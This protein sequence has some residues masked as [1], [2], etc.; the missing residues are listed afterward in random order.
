MRRY[1][2]AFAVTLCLLF[3]VFAPY[4]MGGRNSEF[5]I[6]SAA[7]FAASRDSYSLSSPVRL[8]EAPMIALESGTLSMPHGKSSRGH[9]VIAML[10]TGS[11]A[12]MLLD[13]A[14]F[15]ADFTKS[16]T[17][18]SQDT[19]AG[20]I[21]PLVASFQNLKF[22]ALAVRDS[23]IR[24]K[25]SDG[26][27]LVLDN[28]NADVSA[29]SNGAVRATGS[30]TFRGRPVSFDTTIGTTIDPQQ[31]AR[32][33]AATITSDL[34]NG[35]LN[36]HFTLGASPRLVARDAQ[37][38]V[39]NI[40]KAAHWIGA[41]WPPGTGFENFLV[42]GQLEWGNR[43][44]A[45]VQAHV[46][47]DSN[48][49]NGTLS[50]NFSGPRPAVDG[51]LSLDTLDLT[52]YAAAGEADSQSDV[53]LLNKLRA[54]RGFAFPL[55]KVLDADLRISSGSVV[56]PGMTIGR[57]AA[58]ISLRA[59]KMIADVAELEIDDGTRGGGQ[60][61]IDTNGAEPTY[62]IR[63]KLRS[64]DLGRAGR[65][66][67]GH[68]T[69]EGRG[70]VTVEVTSAGEDGT[71]VLSSLGGKLWVSLN[72]GGR[73]GLDVDQL[74]KAAASTPQSSGIWQAA[75]QSGMSIDT[76]DA[77][78]EVANGVI[79]TEAAQAVTG[80]RAVNAEGVIDLPANR[81]DV[82]LAIGEKPVAD[83]APAPST[84]QDIQVIDL[85]GPW[86][87]PHVAPGKP[88]SVPLKPQAKLPN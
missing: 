38:N 51:T 26:T 48:E 46:A 17:I 13:N 19:P 14:V 72:E 77:R 1:S 78:F 2:L 12:R 71:A 21:A 23:A 20:G 15:T 49:A 33:I 8:V 69:I 40:R 16:D 84:P 82:E 4:L 56:I 85:R 53:S 36:G 64:L 67:F 42:K 70:D 61:R 88:R 83:A 55:I 60:L 29:K 24:L 22:D 37:L 58:T 81:L 75:S 35:T 31:N 57:S 6:R 79:R 7:V 18:F 9:E 3:L 47:M 11:S 50:L 54:T 87:E 59:G 41:G 43:T 25:M 52:K 44:L 86:V 73:F 76:L 34:M 80:S 66:I 74:A 39:P 30:F 5:A 28:V 10:I 32:P 62:D 63:G 45:F 68:P 65:A 27:T